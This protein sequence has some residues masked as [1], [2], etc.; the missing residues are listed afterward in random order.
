M[1]LITEAIARRNYVKEENSLC[2]SRS[3][4]FTPSAREYISDK[5]IKL[6]YSEDKID[7]KVEVTSKKEVTE[8]VSTNK[9]VCK[10][11]GGTI[12][13]KPEHMTQL[14]GNVLVYKFN[15]VIKLRGRLDSLHATAL[16]VGTQ[17]NGNKEFEEDYSDICKFMKN[18]LIAEFTNSPLENI[19]LLGFNENELR[20]R[21]HNP[22]K[23]FGCDHLFGIDNTFDEKTILL[24]KIRAEVR[25]V[26]ILAVEAYFKD[27][28]VEREDIIKALNRLSSAV[29][30][31]M[32]KA[33]GG[34]YE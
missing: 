17:I 8:T 9:Y 12:E 23:Y 29:Y 6:I 7:E 19:N 5:G 4:R 10:Y 21:S 1:A 20:Q 14:H 11:T 28:V 34:K 26:E 32:L 16:A 30:L 2:C 24:N 27:G 33:K 15:K 13:N 25:E 22:K 18:I 31:T 3:D